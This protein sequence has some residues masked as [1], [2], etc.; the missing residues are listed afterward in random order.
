MFRFFELVGVITTAIFISMFASALTNNTNYIVDPGFITKA[1]AEEDDNIYR[2]GTKVHPDEL[3]CMAQN[4]YFESNN[5]S[6]AGQIAVARV[7]INRVLDTRF[8]N[9]VCEVIFETA[10]QL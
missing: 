7:V 6:K 10:V 9:S 2:G 1:V 5:Q 3:E 8:P 4:I